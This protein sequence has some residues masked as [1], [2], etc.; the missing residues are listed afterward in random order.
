MGRE[1]RGSSSVCA[2]RDLS[3]VPGPAGRGVKLAMPT[4]FVTQNGLEIHQST[5]VTI[6]GCAKAK[7][8][9]RAQNLPAALEACNKHLPFVT[10]EGRCS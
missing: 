1:Q 5:P 8:S 6:T 4:L 3:A 2:E 10:E 9:T 7:T